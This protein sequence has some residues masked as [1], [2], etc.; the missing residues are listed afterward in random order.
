M[1]TTVTEKKMKTRSMRG[2]MCRYLGILVAN[3][4]TSLLQDLTV[5]CVSF[6]LSSLFLSR[7]HS[8]RLWQYVAGQTPPPSIRRGE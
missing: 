4:S 3:A 8:P 5:V 1:S 2:T 7:C 6:W